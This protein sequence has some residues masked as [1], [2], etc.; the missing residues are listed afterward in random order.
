M[1]I[2]KLFKDALQNSEVNPPDAIW[3]KI[4]SKLSQGVSGSN[5]A[6]VSTKVMSDSGKITSLKGMA[7]MAT[8]KVA[9][10][11]GVAVATVATAIIVV[12]NIDNKVDSFVENTPK[13]DNNIFAKLDS[14]DA[15][16]LNNIVFDENDMSLMSDKE[17]NTTFEDIKTDEPEKIEI[18][19]DNIEDSD[20][21][22]HSDDYTKDAEI[23]NL[24]E[25][26]LESEEFLN[27]DKKYDTLVEQS[28]EQ[29]SVLPETDNDSI[30]SI[31]EKLSKLVQV[32]ELLDIPNVITPNNDGVNDC[33]KIPEAENY[34]RVHVIVYT[35]SRKVIYENEKYDNTWC[36]T[37]IPGG[38]YF[39]F[40]NIS[41]FDCKPA[42][43]VLYIRTR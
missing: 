17:E 22:I 1:D 19:D 37:D 4:S 42:Q 39:Y 13:E 8:W 38:T 21:K 3:D 36:P 43:G 29:F 5:T 10:I 33:W 16:S 41:D 11:V 27:E 35:I 25:V 40:I 18:L 12:A 15:D 20:E 30:V 23:Y 34:N 14:V 32:A 28:E 9:S 7:K 31:V 6:D 2:D 24:E 26:L